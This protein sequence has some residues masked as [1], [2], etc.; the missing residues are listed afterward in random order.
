MSAIPS[1]QR[2][3]TPTSSQ[4]GTQASSEPAS[5]VAV[6]MPVLGRVQQVWNWLRQSRLSVF[7]QRNRRLRLSETLSLGEKRFVSL[8]EVDNVC[9]LIGSSTQSVTL[10]AQL[11]RS[12]EGQ[13]FRG[14]LDQ[15]W[16]KEGTA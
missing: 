12:S 4:P 9:F 7:A 1:F 16:R 13:P 15:E 6:Q 14:V 8:I 2:L 5:A 10:L 3:V 11:P